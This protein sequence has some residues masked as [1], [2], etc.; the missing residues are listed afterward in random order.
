M[1]DFSISE[2]EFDRGLDGRTPSTVTTERPHMIELHGEVS[3]RRPRSA[4]GCNVTDDD[5]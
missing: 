1:E 5:D 2:E 3:F 4:T